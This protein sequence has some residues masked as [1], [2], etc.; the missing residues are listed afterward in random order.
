[1]TLEAGGRSI[2]SV[3]ADGS[4]VA[5]AGPVK[6]GP[7]L[8]TVAALPVAAVGLAGYRAYVTDATVAYTGANIGSTVVGEGANVVPVFCDGV[9][10]VIG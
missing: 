6:V 1:M 4:G 8:A 10:W 7:T 9:H 5:L 3:P 2:P